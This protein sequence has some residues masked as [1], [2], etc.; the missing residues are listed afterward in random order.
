[1]M[2]RESKSLWEK[3]YAWLTEVEGNMYCKICRKKIIP[4]LYSIARHEKTDEH[5]GKIKNKQTM[6]PLN[7][8]STPRR[9]G[10]DKSVKCAE[11]Q[12]A[13]SMACHCSISAIDHIGEIVG[14]YGQ[15][16][17]LQK[18]QLHKTKCSKVITEVVA[19]SLKEEL[20]RNVQN[21]HFCV[22]I[23]ESTDIG[24]I[25]SLCVCIRYFNDV[26]K[27]IVTAFVGLVDV[28]EATGQ[29]LF[30][31]LRLELETVGLDL[32]NCVGF[33]SDG[34]SAMVGQHNSVWSRIRTVSP[35][36]IL[37]KC[38]VCHS[39]ALCVEHAFE[40]MPSNL[41]FILKEIPKWFSKSIIK[42]EAYKALVQVMDLN[43]EHVRDLPFQ[44]I[45]ATRWLVRG[46]VIYNIL[47]KPHRIHVFTHRSGLVSIY[48]VQY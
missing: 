47:V 9:P 28:V 13:V 25:K 36:C 35:N 1:M 15:G 3:Q 14:K 8:S 12:M 45:S 7:V 2:V 19:V 5:C 31:A 48:T 20:K 24:S 6:R 27:N 30:D 46:K 4:K 41:G 33:A 22:L 10:I 34:A 44:K 38:D 18:M 42:K 16:S 37:M 29:A 40:K 43:R 17:T 21:K 39:L 32:S 26:E 23:D 11:I